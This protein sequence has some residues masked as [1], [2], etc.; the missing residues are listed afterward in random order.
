MS[1]GTAVAVGEGVSVGV[2]VAVAEGVAVGAPVA[3]GVTVPMAAVVGEGLPVTAAEGVAVTTA[4]AVGEATSVSPGEGVVLTIDTRVGV[5]SMTVKVGL[6]VRVG[7][8]FG[9]G[10]GWAHALRSASTAKEQR[11]SLILLFTIRLLVSSKLPTPPCPHSKTGAYWQASQAAG[12]ARASAQN[13]PLQKR[14]RLY[15]EEREKAKRTLKLG[16]TSRWG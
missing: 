2:A 15:H 16:S 11:T 13:N 4:A 12:G 6:G 10:A 5:P 9:T 7:F 1:V 8:G 14:W 3:E